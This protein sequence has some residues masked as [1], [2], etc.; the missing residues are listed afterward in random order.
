MTIFC[1]NLK[2]KMILKQNHHIIKKINK[3]TYKNK[4]LISIKVYYKIKKK[5]KQIKIIKLNR[6]KTII[7]N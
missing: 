4:I 1:L 5:I 7:N 6:I 3:I 2:I